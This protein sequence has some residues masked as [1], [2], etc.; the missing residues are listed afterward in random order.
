MHMHI[1]MHIHIPGYARRGAAA[2]SGRVEGRA[3]PTPSCSA[4]PWQPPSP[5]SPAGMYPGVHV[6]RCAC[7]Q[8]CMYAGVH[9]HMHLA[10][11][12]LAASISCDMHL[13][14]CTCTCPH[15]YA[16]ACV[17]VC[18]CTCASCEA[19]FSS[20]VYMC[21]CMRM[22]ACV[23]MHAHVC[24]CACAPARA[25]QPSSP[26]PSLPRRTCRAAASSRTPPP[27]IAPPTISHPRDRDLAGRA[28]PAAD[29]PPP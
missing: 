29:P 9:V 2:P 8:V 21:I 17:H 15:A 26:A 14:P 4:V 22:C 28:L 10:A 5:S 6:S 11:F 13:S 23:H 25:V 1:H 3:A 27:E 7:T 24:M 18:M 12:I 16:C 19:I 20:A